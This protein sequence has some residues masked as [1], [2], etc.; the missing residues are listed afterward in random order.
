VLLNTYALLAIFSAILILA[1]IY[2]DFADKIKI[3]A[4]ILLIATGVGL[5]ELS[6]A[7]DIRVADLNSLLPTVGTVALLLI[8]LEG[9]LE[10]RIHNRTGSVIQKT[11]LSATAGIVLTSLSIAFFISLI[12]E[13]SMRQSLIS[14]IPFSIISSAVAIPTVSNLARSKKDFVIYESTLSDIIGIVFFNFMVSNEIIDF[15]SFAELGGNLLAIIAISFLSTFALIFALKHLK[16]KARFTLIIS[17]LVLVYSTSKMLHLSA[18]VVVLVFGFIL[19]NIDKIK[20]EWFSRNFNYAKQKV[21]TKTLYSFT[22][23]LAFAAKALMF[24]L[25]G[26][27]IDQKEI[28]EVSSIVN[29]LAIIAIYLIIRYLVL[30]AL[31][32]PKLPNLF[33]APKG[34]ITIILFI[35]IPAKEAIDGISSGTVLVVVIISCAIMPIGFVLSNRNE[36]KAKDTKDKEN[37]NELEVEII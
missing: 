18:L 9:A 30:L 31:I 29:G 15:N 28:T 26:F 2:D 10:L 6:I 7:V 23:E 36:Q 22:T 11:A 33:I 19:N 27:T 20:I 34:L 12:T 5:K 16:S 32:L 1:F 35:S 25:F 13:E 24:V 4:I 8:V 3:P 37:Y 14:A 17:I 21:D